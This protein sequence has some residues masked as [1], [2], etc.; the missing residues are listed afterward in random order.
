MRGRL[1]LVSESGGWVEWD[2]ALWEVRVKVGV[3][4]NDGEAGER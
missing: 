1:C 2:S 4:G 3:P